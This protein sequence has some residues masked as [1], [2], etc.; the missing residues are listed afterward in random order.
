[1]PHWGG[2]DPWFTAPLLLTVAIG[3]ALAIGLRLVV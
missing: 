2:G 1:L 3:L